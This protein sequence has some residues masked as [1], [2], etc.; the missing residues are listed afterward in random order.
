MTG[1]AGGGVP[2]WNRTNLLPRSLSVASIASFTSNHF[3]RVTRADA[4]GH[5][6]SRGLRAG[7]HQGRGLAPLPRWLLGD[8][9]ML[10]QGLQARSK[11]TAHGLCGATR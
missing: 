8:G 7:A 6:H 5:P 3:L 4:A 9:W 1:H 10:T 11:E 2:A